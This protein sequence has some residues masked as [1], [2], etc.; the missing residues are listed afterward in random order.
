MITFDGQR[1]YLDANLFIYLIEADDFPQQ[2]EAVA[3][4]F[5]ALD[6]GK[7]TGVVSEL[8]LGE[9][10]PI[11][12]RED[13]QDRVQNYRQIFT[14]ETALEVQPI[15]LPIIDAAAVLRAHS[16][17]KTPDALHLATAI[18]HSCD[19]FL[20]NDRKLKVPEGL[21]VQIVTLN[22]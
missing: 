1:V 2:R 10:L 18:E 8:A 16:S 9:V 5:A 3:A 15:T 22:E 7:I 20:T 17:L 11:P 14:T 13:R 21:P 19:L 6:E 12:L 4:I